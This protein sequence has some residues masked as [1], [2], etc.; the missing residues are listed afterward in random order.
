MSFYKYLED[1]LEFCEAEVFVTECPSDHVVV[2]TKAEYGRMQ[3]GR[4]VQRSY[5][6]IGCVADVLVHLDSICSGRR[7]CELRIP[8]QSLDKTKPCPVDLKTYLNVS[9]TCLEGIFLFKQ[10]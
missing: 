3:F 4:C 2:I 5:G 1:G 7:K 8:D 9:Y 6:S 10:Q